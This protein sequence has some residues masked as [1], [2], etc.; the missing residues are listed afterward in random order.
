MMLMS[1]VAPEVGSVM[2]AVGPVTVK[3]SVVA[4]LPAPV[5]VTPPE[6]E[7]AL[8]IAP[9]AKV[10]TTLPMPRAFVSV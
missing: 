8:R 4:A 9:A 6:V 3:P 1:M 2:T 7:S 10:S 5:V